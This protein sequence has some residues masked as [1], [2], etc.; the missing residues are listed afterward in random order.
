MSARHG[1]P[2]A[3]GYPSAAWVP[4]AVAVAAWASP[5]RASTSR[6]SAQPYENPARVS[7]SCLF[8]KSRNRRSV[9]DGGPG[10]PP[11]PGAS[12]LV[13]SRRPLGLSCAVPCIAMQRH[14]GHI[15]AGEYS[16]PTGRGGGLLS[17][18]GFPKPGVARSSRAGGASDSAGVFP[19][20]WTPLP[21]LVAGFALKPQSPACRKWWRAGA[22]S[23]RGPL[24]TVPPG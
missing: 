24:E 9:N 11:K 1:R 7:G 13:L 5:A 4:S 22:P 12:N 2:R 20:P 17:A 6:W 15:T 8:S 16:V 18:A 23:N 10:H 3:S 21:N 19:D 14:A